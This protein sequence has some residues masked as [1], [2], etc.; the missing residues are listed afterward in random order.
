ML[1]SI[2]RYRHF[3]LASIR[4][5]LKGRFAR[6]RLGAFW[7]ILHPLAQAL[8]FS[9]ILAEVMRARLPNIDN[10]AAYPIYLLSGMAAWGLFSEILNRSIS[11]FIEQASAMKKIAFPRLC[12]PMIVWGS[13]LINHVL[14]LVAIAVIFLFFGHYPGLAWLYLIPGMVLISFMAFGIGVFLG[15]LNVFARDVAQFMTVF[16]QLWFWFTPIV[17]LKS[18][19]PEQFQFFIGLNPMTA[20]VGLYQDALLLDKAPEWSALWPA[21]IVGGV[22]VLLSFVVF[23]RASPELVDAL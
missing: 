19:V 8:I 1:S 2:W 3:I 15:V 4:G 9:I 16:M 13:A 12:L 14:L 22:A 7:F 11:I 10:Q 6:S 21:V 5:D 20:L 18:V 17:Y 23:R